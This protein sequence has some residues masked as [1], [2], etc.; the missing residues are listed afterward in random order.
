MESVLPAGMLAERPWIIDVT[1]LT[2]ASK[3]GPSLKSRRR[4]VVAR[5]ER[6]GS[7]GVI[8]YAQE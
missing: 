3:S 2:K 8:S 7:K 6:S 5:I 4:R 1:I